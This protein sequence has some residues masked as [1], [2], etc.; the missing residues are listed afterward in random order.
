MLPFHKCTEK[1]YA[2]FYPV[3]DSSSKLL[4][5][6]RNNPDRGLLCVDWTDNPIEFVG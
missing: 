2:E 5:T 4:E 3:K 1:D 6:V